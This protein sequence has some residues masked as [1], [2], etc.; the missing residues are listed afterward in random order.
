M[1][2]L[3]ER[4]GP[5]A[6]LFVLF[7]GLAAFATRPLVRDL[8]G[9]LPVGPD[10]LIDLWTVD[11]LSAHALSP[12]QLFQGNIFHP[13]P[14]AVLHSDLSLGT[15]LLVAP[16]RLVVRDPVPLYNV[17]LMLSL[18]FGAWGFAMLV[19]RLTGSAWAAAVTGVWAAFGSH[20]LF[21]LYHLNLLSIGWLG[22]LLLAL[23]QLR[24]RPGPRAVVLAGVAFA[25]NALSS[26][27]YAVAAAL[28][29]LGFGLAHRELWRGRAL[30]GAFAA[31]LLAGLL[32]TP[33]LLAVSELRREDRSF[34]RPLGMSAKMAFDPR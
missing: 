12:A 4:C 21:H 6:A 3:A 29:A 17:A 31:S 33:Y 20:Q 28:L 16:L 26:G 5:P 2:R 27:Y 15:A 30:A 32:L 7:L 9:S 14:Y 23:E 13:Y 11:W 22:L 34:T 25:L 19:H 8:Q 24:T 10:P 1:R 18:A